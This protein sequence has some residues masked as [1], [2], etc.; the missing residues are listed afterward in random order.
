MQKKYFGRYSIYIIFFLSINF[1]S[2]IVAAQSYTGYHSST[3]AGV[4]GILT[5]PA[6]ILNHRFRGDINLAGISVQAQNNTV[7][8]KYAKNADSTI[9]ANPITKHGKAYVNTDVFGPSFLIKLSD[10][11][12]FAVTSRVRAITNV[13]NVSSDLLNTIL[14]DSVYNNVSIKN[15][16][17]VAHAWTEI[18]LTYSRQVAISDYGVWKAGV[19]LKYLNGLGTATVFAN[20]LKFVHDSIFNPASPGGR[21]DAILNAQGKIGIH[22][23][24]NIDSLS[25]DFTNNLFKNPGAGIDI[26]VSYEYRDEMQVYETSYSE[27]TRNYIWKAG[28]SI[29]DIGFIRY[30]KNMVKQFGANFSGR[31]YTTDE[32]DPPSDSSSVQQM[33]NYYQTLFGTKNSVAEAVD[34][35]LPA[36]LHLSY[37]RFFNR[38]LGA[39]AQINVP[40]VFV[41]LKKYSGNLNPVSVSVTP[42]AEISWCGLYLPVSYNSISGFQAGMSI[43]LGP[44]VIGSASLINTGV[45][46][47]TKGA[48]AYFILRIPFFGY[49]DY[50]EKTAREKKTKTPKYLGCK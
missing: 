36:T 28:A 24:K 11:H 17:M 18:A 7:A 42:R 27:L 40:L 31:N 35:Q 26:G 6:D 38:W 15:I 8:F 2:L 10:K 16:A 19:S 20:D 41:S 44:L 29:T 14:Q 25:D 23:T 22:Y 49:R 4:Y 39:Q 48:D 47:K 45:L 43:R 5:N 13:S 30:Q 21:Q 9:F 50:K 34:V 46:R 33:A 3:Y 32:L 37:D 1:S 12:A